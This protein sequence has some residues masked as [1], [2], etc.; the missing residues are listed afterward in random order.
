MNSKRITAIDTL[1]GFALLGILLMNI[2]SFSMPD[3]AYYNP[4]VYGG[5]DFWNQLEFSVM[6]VLADQ[7]FMALFSLL[8][9]A[10]MMLLIQKLKSQQRPA[11]RIHYIRNGWLLVFGLLHMILLWDGDILLVYAL[12]GM[13]LYPL[14]RLPPAWQFGLGL[15][16]FL[17]PIA[18]FVQ[19]LQTVQGFSAAEL[20]T[21]QN[22]WHPPLSVIQQDIAVYQSDFLNQMAYRLGINAPDTP[23][24]RAKDLM[25]GVVLADG[26]ARALGMML[27]GMALYTWGIIT[28]KASTQLY[29]RCVKVGFGIGLPLS[30]FAL[31]QQHQHGWDV[32]HSLFTGKMLSSLYTPFMAAGYLG[33]MMLWARSERFLILQQRLTT[34][35]QMALSNYIGQS[36]LAA[37][38]FT[39]LGLYGKVNRMEQ[40]GI[41]LLIWGVQLT[42]S[43]WWLSRCQYG[44]L[45]WLWRSLTYRRVERL[46]RKAE[47]PA[48]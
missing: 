15:M 35:G 36:I 27:C 9:G 23:P 22:L 1:R 30:L 7:K 8:F 37:L 19:G 21:L 32:T 41:V 6:Y 48:T 38:I 2:S 43:H 10:S 40:L 31:Y 47:T 45:E 5:T 33:M 20:K 14:H 13:V 39:G 29:S 12:C 25:L 11:A 44:P 42:F 4:N 17:S 3:E 34:L 16:L 18:L 24:S 26:F 28:G 46:Q